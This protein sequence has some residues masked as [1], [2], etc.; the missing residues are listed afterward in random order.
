MFTELDKNIK[1]IK[2]VENEAKKEE[3]TWKKR[4]DMIFKCFSCDSK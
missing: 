3:R 1:S 2:K 4:F